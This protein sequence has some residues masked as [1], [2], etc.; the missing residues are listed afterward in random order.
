MWRDGPR[1]SANPIRDVFDAAAHGYN[2][3]LTCRGCK[4]V[5]V[6][7]SAGVWNLFQRKRWR[8]L[9]SDLAKHFRC[10]GCSRKGPDIALV[11][12]EPT[13][14]ELPMPWESEWKRELRRR[15]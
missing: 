2:L 8:D 15:R 4:R 5:V 10:R 9:M 13:S 11:H 1:H 7:H 12:E 14:T 6:L 3:R